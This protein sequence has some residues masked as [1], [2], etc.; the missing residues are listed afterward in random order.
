MS[1]EYLSQSTARGSPALT[2]SATQRIRETVYSYHRY[3]EPIPQI[4]RDQFS[5]SGALD[6]AQSVFRSSLTQNSAAGAAN[7]VVVAKKIN[8]G[9]GEALLMNQVAHPNIVRLLAVCPA[10]QHEQDD[11]IVMEP[12]TCDAGS[13]VRDKTG[14]RCTGAEL[15]SLMMQVA[16]ALVHLHT[17][18]RCAHMDLKPENV[19]LFDDQRVAKLADL[20]VSLSLRAKD[21]LRV[22]GHT[23][24]YAPPEQRAG[25]LRNHMDGFA[26]D[27]YAVGGI[28]FEALTGTTVQSQTGSIQVDD[29]QIPR[30]EMTPRWSSFSDA[31]RS[32]LLSL[33][34]A[35]LSRQ[36]ARR[37]SAM[38]LRSELTRL[39]QHGA[40]P[41]LTGPVAD[42]SFVHRE[43]YARQLQQS[44]SVHPVTI[45]HGPPGMG[46]TM[47]AREYAETSLGDYLCVLEAWGASAAAA[48]E[49]LYDAVNLILR[50][51]LQ[52]HTGPLD[53]SVAGG[54]LQAAARDV[55]AFL[56]R[57]R[58]QLDD[59]RPFLIIFDGADDLTD[60]PPVLRTLRSAA[61]C[62]D[63]DTRI[64]VTTIRPP[65]TLIES[66]QAAERNMHWIHVE[67]FNDV[68]VR[69]LLTQRL[70]L[71]DAD[72]Q[73]AVD[74]LR[75]A[76]GMR[77]WAV[78][79]LVSIAACTG[80]P[81]RS[82]IAVLLGGGATLA[83]EID[84]DIRHRCREAILLQLRGE[85][86]AL[87]LYE[88]AMS[89]CSYSTTLDV[90]I[91]VLTAVQR[92]Y[93]KW[94]QVAEPGGIVGSTPARRVAVAIAA[95]TA[96]SAGALHQLDLAARTDRN[97]PEIDVGGLRPMFSTLVFWK[98]L[99]NSHRAPAPALIALTSLLH[100]CGARGDADEGQPLDGDDLLSVLSDAATLLSHADDL[101][102]SAASAFTTLAQM[103][104]KAVAG[105]NYD[106]K[107]LASLASALA[108]FGS[109][110][111]L[112]GNNAEGRKTLVNAESAALALRKRLHAGVDHP[113]LAASLNSL[114]SS[115][116]AMGDH[117][118]GMAL[119][120]EAMEMVRRLHVSVDHPD[121]AA[122]LNNVG[123][124]VEA[125]GDGAAGMALKVES[126]EMMRRLHGSDHADLAASLNNVGH[127]L[128]VM[129][130]HA[131]GVVLRLG[132]LGMRRR[133]YAGVDH[134]DM[135]ASLNS[136]G[137]SLE[138]MGDRAAG[139]ALKREALEMRR[140]LYAGV[141][142][143]D[144]AASLNNVGV[145][146]EAMGDRAAS[147]ALKREALEMM[148]R[149]YFGVD[150]PD[151]AASLNNVGV[152]LEAMG[153]RVAG[154]TLQREALEM[155]RRL[156]ANVDHP[157][158]AASL[159]NIG[160]SLEAMGDRPVGM[161][162]QR[163]ALE[164]RRRLYRGVDHPDLAASLNNVGG[165]LTA[166]GNCVAGAALQREAL[167]MRRR[168]HPDVDHPDLARSLS[169]VGSSLTA[170]GDRV[171]GAALQR[172]ALEMRRRLY[173]GDDHPDLAASLNNVGSTL[174][175]MGDRAA[176]AASL[177]E[178]LEMRRRL[179]AGIDHPD[180]A[181]SLNN[182][183]TSLKAMGDCAAG[184]TLQREALEMM[185]RL[186]AG[187]DHPD[188]A[189]SLNN[190][191]TSFVAMGDRV[192][193]M[194]LK[195]EALEMRRRLCGGDHP[196]L[197]A[198]LNDVG[199][200][201]VAMGDRTAGAALQREALEMRRRL[202]A[203]VDHPDL[204]ASLSN[205]G[206]SWEA[207]GN[208]APGLALQRE[209]LEMRRRLYAGV[210]HPDMAASL[211]NVGISL[212]SMGDGAAGVALQLEALEMM[213][214]LYAGGDHADLAASL[215]N[216]GNSLAAMGDCAGVALQREALEM[217]RTLYAGVDHPDLAASFRN[218]GFSCLV[219]GDRSAACSLL[220]DEVL[221]RMRLSLHRDD[222]ELALA[223]Y[224]YSL[225]LPGGG[226]SP[227]A[228]F[229]SEMAFRIVLCHFSD[230]PRDGV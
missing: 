210:D 79:R 17:R 77:P 155:R 43:V 28:L 185:R 171:A 221:L 106:D 18:L 175:A 145:S 104:L 83:V 40:F 26:C 157:D 219:A 169:N 35:C 132:A 62:G 81:L 152:S 199:T 73:A 4:R 24:Q 168:L 41:S 80:R 19:L 21:S 226:G 178:A 201:F 60:L 61:T 42:H 95:I 16:E 186:Y 9:D 118:V 29:P 120:H 163:E 2:L 187:V 203:G 174:E 103:G 122:A 148:R 194:S 36:A 131:A 123:S 90:S 111:R 142:H 32:Q 223:L 91:T 156:H 115:L 227:I 98:A 119:Q 230:E 144:L 176:G 150:H 71:V 46:K 11:W 209:A 31:V 50:P 109:G 49:D 198:S 133:L 135:A 82:E 116:E 197:A 190:V 220:R 93:A 70:G 53:Y 154:L 224:L 140:R 7:E 101:G 102:S 13:A 85:P 134:P 10:E 173:R 51:Q 218:V 99:S 129:G 228:T 161:V 143:P 87:Q 8:T 108:I 146:L 48:M 20:G 27:I 107:Q 57:A 52:P 88:D 89:F 229:A 177:S 139:V 138:E 45:L 15:L 47:L 68:D 165:A 125:M 25:K 202:Y 75:K 39:Q 179:H 158:L 38:A 162:L 222:R 112:A 78:T 188:L 92:G 34:A 137:A 214:R 166:T 22:A 76:T 172:E 12:A 189:A 94:R 206:T 204:A 86:E 69:T 44:L 141:D 54:D 159:N 63:V 193:G 3:P 151:L 191:G 33:C 14:E 215:S 216:V 121:L 195:R 110:G 23:P 114:G 217:R 127:S 65:P 181:A 58:A 66:L 37:P 213:R 74:P 184:T 192:A 67:V 124:S 55:T 72:A 84:A 167:E 170:M 117:A 183:G 200:S 147:V 64:L 96:G 153:D 160:V 180:L 207:M 225:S 130:D 30:S 1:V 105:P 100:Q 56:Q 164:M 211:S 113:Y 205:V 149:L 212:K 128:I 136:V 196:D 182:V 208:G 126:L 6:P 5:L 59:P 97:E